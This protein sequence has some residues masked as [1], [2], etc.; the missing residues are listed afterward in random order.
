MGE[1]RLL[2]IVRGHRMKRVL[3]RMLDEAELLS[4]YG[5]RAL[6]RSQM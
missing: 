2:A 1:R 6:S 4:K 5:I 3:R